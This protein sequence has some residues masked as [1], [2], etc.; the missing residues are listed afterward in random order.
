MPIGRVR[1]SATYKKFKNTAEFK[2]VNKKLVFLRENLSRA[3]RRAGSERKEIAIN[4]DYLYELGE[5]Q[6]WRCALADT[7]LEFDRGGQWFGGNWSNPNSCTIDRID[8]SKGYLEDNVQLLSWRINC[9]KGGCS[10][11]EYI[12][13]CKEIVRQTELRQSKNQDTINH[14]ALVDELKKLWITIQNYTNVK[15]KEQDTHSK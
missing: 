9:T 8:S 2:Q 7:P 5:K 1:D 4:I 13:I 3:D 14:E 10:Q 11:E 15:T 12:E 6:Q